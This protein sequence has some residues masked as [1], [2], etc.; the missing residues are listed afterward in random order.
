MY[1]EQVEHNVVVACLHDEDFIRDV[2]EVLSPNHFTKAPLKWL[3]W[4]AKEHYR[5]YGELI[6]SSVVKTELQKSKKIPDKRKVLYLK[7]AGD[8]LKEKP[9]SRRYSKDQVI[10]YINDVTFIQSLDNASQVI[11]QGNIDK[12]RRILLNEIL[13]KQTT[14]NYKISNWLKEFENRQNERKNR[15]KQSVST[16][17]A[18]PPYGGLKRVIDVIQPGEIASVTGITSSGKSIMLHDWGRHNF[19]NGLNVLHITLENSEWQTNQRYDSNILGVPYDA[20]KRY[21]FTTKQ[22]N[23]IKRNIG[24]LRKAIGERLMVIQCP[25]QGTDTLLLEKVARELELAGWYAHFVILDYADIMKAVKGWEN[26]RLSQGGVYWD[27]KAWAID[28]GLP[29]LTATQAK[30]EYGVPDRKGRILVP[31]AEAASESYWKPRIL[32]IMLTIYQTQKQKFQGMV[33]AHVAKNRDGAKGFE[34]PLRED[35]KNIRFLE[36]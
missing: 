24:A 11:E 31:T 29:L 25:M 2:Y 36:V 1:N 33:T 17:Y 13:I 32:D 12:A 21:K 4:L 23:Q 14:K 22:L 5:K 20:L 7:I 9:K 30:A 10:E 6:D 16:I 19:L 26:F 18:E 35:F 28:R 34:L 27:I 8:L 15:K 3:Y